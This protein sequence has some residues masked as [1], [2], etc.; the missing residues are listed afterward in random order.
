MRK[1]KR[2]LS[3]LTVMALWLL[4]SAFFWSWIFTILTD[5]PRAQKLVLF[6]DAP[7]PGATELAAA[8]EEGMD[9][10]LR[11]VQA[12]PFSFAMLNSGPL[13]LADL[14]I[15]RSSDAQTY[16]E[17]EGHGDAKGYSEAEERQALRRGLHHPAQRKPGRPGEDPA[18]GAD[19]PG[20]PEGQGGRDLRQ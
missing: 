12:H 7:M 4:I 10:V 19:R 15:V 18:A 14:Y 6:A 1:E 2:L 17:T 11:M 20:F 5:A 13:R 3:L 9:P 8:L 16:G